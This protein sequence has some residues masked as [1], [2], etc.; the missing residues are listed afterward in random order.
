MPLDTCTD[1]PQRRDEWC[2]AMSI[3]VG[4]Q[5][6]PWRALASLTLTLHERGHRCRATSDITRM[7]VAYD[8]LG[9]DYD[10]YDET[11]VPED[12]LDRWCQDAGRPEPRLAGTT[13][14]IS[15][16]HASFCFDAAGR[17]VGVQ[18]DETGHWQ[19]RIKR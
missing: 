8:D 17:L 2:T 19:P 5:P 14:R 9:V 1:C 12:E 13:H 15:V 6:D 3:D 4:L 18:D 10:V 7:A 11:A 16:A